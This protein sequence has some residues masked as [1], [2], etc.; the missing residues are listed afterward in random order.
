MSERTFSDD[1]VRD[2]LE[3]AA[4]RQ[5]AADKALVRTRP[6]MSLAELEQIASEA[7]ISPEHVR[8]VAL[9]GLDRHHVRSAVPVLT[10]NAA[11]EVGLLGE[12]TFPGRV[13]D[14]AWGRIVQDLRS[15]FN[16]VGQATEFGQTREWLS[17]SAT[18]G[19]EPVTV[20]MER[21]GE[22]TRLS[23][24]RGTKQRKG[25]AYG[26]P[27]MFA[28]AAVVFTILF[29][30]TGEAD[31][32][33]LPAFLGILGGLGGIVGPVSLRLWTASQTK[34]FQE[35]MDRAQLLAAADPGTWEE[36]E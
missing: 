28:G 7:G 29:L 10:R 13:S 1:E 30:L 21:E 31:T 2:I 35:V 12:R 19:M 23:M 8:A 32:W 26:I 20:R 16:V 36:D 3:R 22:D 5:A 25:L 34:K 14:E 4:D 15:T 6:G 11:G 27:V 18:G 17:V 33:G 24:F 9:Q